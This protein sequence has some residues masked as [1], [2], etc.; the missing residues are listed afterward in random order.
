MNKILVIDNEYDITELIAEM[1]SIHGFDVQKALDGKSGIKKAIKFCPDLILCD[2]AMPETSGYDVLEVLRKDMRT[3][4]I[5]FIFLTA[6]G[7]MQDLRKGMRLGADDYLT[8][9]VLA[10]ELIAAVKTRLEKHQQ[11]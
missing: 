5:P 2:I 1:L 10:D 11:I 8:K 3:H 9:P 7:G 6:K 4:S